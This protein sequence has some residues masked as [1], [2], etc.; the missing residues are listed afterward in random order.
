MSDT[1]QHN[2]HPQDPARRAKPQRF[3]V[4]EESSTRTPPNPMRNL[5]DP[6]AEVSVGPRSASRPTVALKERTEQKRPAIVGVP[7]TESEPEVAAPVAKSAANLH[8]AQTYVEPPVMRRPS[9][10][11]PGDYGRGPTLTEMALSGPGLAAI[12]SAVCLAIIYFFMLQPARVTFSNFT[13]RAPAIAAEAAA[14]IVPQLPT[15]PGENSVVGP[16]SVTAATIDAILAAYGS[17]AAGTGRIWVELG[18]QYQI[19]PAYAVAFFIHES[20]AGT[21]QG[22]AGIKPDGSTTHNVGNIICAGYPTCFNRFRDYPNW[23]TGIE[24]WYKLISVEYIGGRGVHTVEQII[25]IYAPSFENNV[26]AYVNA[27]NSLVRSWRA[28]GTGQ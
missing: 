25:P 4:R 13:E 8:R 10:P 6:F 18:Q 23:E 15:A 28:G 19:D 21:N 12:I 3:G 1:D 9:Y 2:E 16:P 17:P 26:P 24:D 22:W 20:S 14:A 7:V 11:A 5:R 27:V